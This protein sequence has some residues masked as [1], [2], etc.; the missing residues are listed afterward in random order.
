[1]QFLNRCSVLFWSNVWLALVLNRS[2]LL[3]S[4]IASACFSASNNNNQM[5][6]YRLPFKNKNRN[7]VI[8]LF[9]DQSTGSEI[10]NY[11]KLNNTMC[12]NWCSLSNWMYDL[13]V[14]HWCRQSSLHCNCDNHLTLRSWVIWFTWVMQFCNRWSIL[15]CFQLCTPDVIMFVSYSV[16]LPSAYFVACRQSSLMC[17]YTIDNKHGNLDI[18]G[19]IPSSSRR[20]WRL[21]VILK[22]TMQCVCTWC[23]LSSWMFDLSVCLRQSSLHYNGMFRWLFLRHIRHLYWLVLAC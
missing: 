5:C 7:M 15:F 18:L 23:S 22:W 14:C 8:W 9:W 20:A 2:C 13:S 1:M 16:E 3:V 19:S 6:W 4:W 11:I 17:W 21:T 10:D 12:F